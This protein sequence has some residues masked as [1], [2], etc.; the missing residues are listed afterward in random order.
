MKYECSDCGKVFDESEAITRT[1]TGVNCKTPCD[2]DICPFCLS[3]DLN[4]DYKEPAPEEYYDK[5]EL[6][7]EYWDD[8]ERGN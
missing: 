6:R 5:E 3:E 8:V 7:G 2:Y 1:T 4:E